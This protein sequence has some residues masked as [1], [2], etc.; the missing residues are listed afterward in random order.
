MLDVLEAQQ[1]SSAADAAAPCGP[2]YTFSRNDIA[3]QGPLNSL[4]NGVGRP[5]RRTR[6]A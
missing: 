5:C 4:V 1:Q 2:A 3:G 6:L